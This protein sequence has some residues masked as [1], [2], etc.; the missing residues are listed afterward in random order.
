VRFPL[1]PRTIVPSILFP[2]VTGAGLLL[3]AET[4]GGSPWSAAAH[5]IVP[6]VVRRR[7]DFRETYV[8]V[9]DA[10][11]GQ[12]GVRVEIAGEEI[13]RRA[14]VIAGRARAVPE[15]VARRGAAAGVNGGFFGAT[16]EG[17]FREIVGLLKQDGRV[18]S[19]APRFGGGK[20]GRFTHAALGIFP[21][22]RPAIAWT[23]GRSGR[24]Q[25][26]L[27]YPTP[28]ISGAGRPWEPREAVGCGPRL[29]R[30]GKVQVT[31]RGERLLSR[32]ALPRTFLGFG[33]GGAS[34]HLAL[35]V[36]P[37]MEFE[38][39]ASFLDAYYRR[40]HRTPCAEGMALDGGGSTQAAWRDGNRVSADPPYG[41][42]VPTAVLIY[43]R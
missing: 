17:G 33:P 34:G 25:E 31:A 32:G 20:R 8:T 35:C 6:G 13:S 22:G 2:L 3:A 19:A 1:S 23:A 15:W 4:R 24:P 12:R 21:D 11:L 39:C 16:L 42:P 7:L 10:D 30:A 26:L 36:T 37:A 43:A 29:V 18:R 5:P 38:D 27:A 14:G 40:V 9:I 41:T 28:S